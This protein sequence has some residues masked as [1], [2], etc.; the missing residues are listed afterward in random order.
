MWC[1][2]L[3]RSSESS[4]DSTLEMSSGLITPLFGSSQSSLIQ[5]SANRAKAN[6]LDADSVLDN[7][8][9]VASLSKVSSSSAMSIFLDTM[10]NPQQTA[11]ST[12]PRS[13]WNGSP[14]L[15]ARALN[16]NATSSSSSS[17]PLDDLI[18][19]SLAGLAGLTNQLPH[20]NKY[21]VP[22]EPFPKSKS[23]SI[24]APTSVSGASSSSSSLNNNTS[25]SC[26][27]SG[28]S[29]APGSD[30]GARRI[31]HRA[32]A[33]H[34]MSIISPIHPSQPSHGHLDSLV[35]AVENAAFEQQKVDST[36]GFVSPGLWLFTDSCFALM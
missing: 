7:S 2:T 18:S 35:A 12:L 26:I 34:A 29:S 21:H 5:V 23:T 9:A 28:L 33:S 1:L 14:A 27:V 6:D 36:F 20:V 15:N 24:S 16:A 17:Q 3:V 19:Q 30:R 13:S 10:T 32:Q 8:V 25:P 22:K 4:P 31:A 11:V